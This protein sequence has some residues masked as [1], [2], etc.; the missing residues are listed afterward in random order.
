MSYF[1]YCDSPVPAH[2][3]CQIWR[4]YVVYGNSLKVV[5]MSFLLFVANIVC[6]IYS[7]VEQFTHKSIYQLAKMFS[8]A[9]WTM[10]VAQNLLTT[11]TPR[12]EPRLVNYDAHDKRVV[13]LLVW[14]IWTVDRRNNR[15]YSG[16]QPSRKRSTSLTRIV[17][18]IA[19]SGVLYTLST[20]VFL[21]TQV[22]SSYAIFPVS[23][24]VSFS[25]VAIVT[26][27]ILF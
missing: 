26:S 20:F 13:G 3:E 2:H 18:T 14:K 8:I 27:P 1:A 4:T 7:T 19:G 21:V 15:L 24:T 5:S 16:Q 22:V 9:F 11:G 17:R 25:A 10:T 12:L 23:V 6:A